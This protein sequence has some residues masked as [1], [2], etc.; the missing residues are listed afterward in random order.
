MKDKKRTEHGSK[1]KA[2]SSKPSVKP[3]K[4]PT[5]DDVA[6]KPEHPGNIPAG[7]PA[8]PVEWGEAYEAPDDDDATDATL[9]QRRDADHSGGDSKRSM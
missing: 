9:D 6:V 4:A 1:Q 2:R 7:T 5:P 8:N 3:P